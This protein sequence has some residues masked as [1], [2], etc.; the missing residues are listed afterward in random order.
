MKDTCVE[1]TFEVEPCFKESYEL[2]SIEGQSAGVL[3]FI[4]TTRLIVRRDLGIFL[5]QE[6]DT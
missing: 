4:K 1:G 6:N 5:K 3:G 2:Q